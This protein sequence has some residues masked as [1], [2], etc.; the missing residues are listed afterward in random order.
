MIMSTR[1]ITIF[2]IICTII[3]FADA[4]KLTGQIEKKELQATRVQN[5]PRID[6]NLDDP[7]WENVPEASDFIQYEPYNDRPASQSTVVKFL[8]DDNAIYIGAMLFDLYP[9]SILT[10]LGIR[11]A[12][13]NINADQFSIDLNPYNDG[14]NGFTFK[15]S[16]SGVQTDVNRSGRG[17]RFFGPGTRGDINWD[18]VW[19]SDVQITDEGWSVEIEIPYSALRFPDTEVKEWGINFWRDLRRHTE[20]SSWNFVDRE[21]RN[22]MNYLGILKGIEGVKPPLRL[23]IYPYI[24]GYIE[25]SGSESSWARS[26]HGGIDLK[27]GITESFTMD[28]TLIPDFGQ[29]KTDEKILNLTPFEVR[30]EERRQFFTEG[31]E[32]FQRANLFYSRRIGSEPDGYEDVEDQLE[33][34]EKISKNPVETKMV[35]ATKISGRTNKGLGIGLLN[36][37][38]LKSIAVV[39][40]T[41]TGN[42]REIM[43]QPFTN[44]NILVFDQSL[45]N[46][47]FVSLINT[48]TFMKD[49]GYMANVTGSELSFNDKSN[50]YGVRVEFAVSQQYYENE[51][52]NFGYKYDISAGKF[53]G[54][55]QYRLSRELVSD[56]YDQNDLGYLRRNNEIENQASFDYNI[57]Q[58]FGNFL[59]FGTGINIDYDQLYY[60]RKFTQLR[61]GLDSRA[62]FIN[63]F[64]IFIRGEYSPLGQKDYYEPRVDGRYYFIDESFEVFTRFDT[65][66]RKKVA[67]SGDVSFQ[68]IYSAYQQKQF[69]FE[70]TPRFRINDKFN[71][72]IGVEHRKR[73]KDIGYITDYGE[74]SVYFGMRNSPTW[75]STI[76]ANYIF[77]NNISLG[78]DLRHY[79]SRVMYDGSYYFLNEDGSLSL[80]EYD[81][82]E[83][84]IN[85]NAFTIDMVFKWNFA[86][87][88]WLTAV[89]KNIVDTEG[90]LVNNY[91]QNIDEMFNEDQI[92]SLSIKVL[93]YLDYQY[94]NNIFSKK[95]K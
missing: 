59:S 37:M 61:I 5:V 7:V 76:K 46:N 13:N 87:G 78:F 38:T 16:A 80:L 75:I 74:D 53:G 45:P 18:A 68:R 57:Y 91:F 39:S 54:K 77:T 33:E 24:S 47:S 42:E 69:S 51:D 62:E 2:L 32:L 14:V 35:N 70:L 65:D 48:N 94:I 43:T 44:Y 23:A 73:I 25:K 95:Q 15:V 86:P 4:Q 8:Y 66:R 56:T 10:E 55:I 82:R 31:T 58:P 64:N 19:D 52:N 88:S 29:V 90:D 71:W 30:Y 28:L 36:A 40:D 11:D 81:L 17:R 85:Y 20:L 21:V 84:D 34:S 1:S 60:P 26:L 93:Y 79:W 9:D 92:N 67:L 22:Q 50:L 41:I 83:E 49:I 89:W 27:W 72:E 3:Q 12:D 63:R 6:G